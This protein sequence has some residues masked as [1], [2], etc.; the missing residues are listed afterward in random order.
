M[1]AR[2]NGR[3]RSKCDD[4]EQRRKLGEPGSGARDHGKAHGGVRSMPRLTRNTAQGFLIEEEHGSEDDHGNGDGG[5]A[6]SG[7]NSNEMT[8][9]STSDLW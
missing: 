9:A 3:Q 7:D 8:W 4:G 1:G 6:A 2:P 5:S